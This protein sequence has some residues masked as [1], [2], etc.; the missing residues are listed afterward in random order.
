MEPPQVPGL[1]DAHW[2]EPEKAAGVY[3]AL[4]RCKG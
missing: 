1:E 4:V 3:L 2:I